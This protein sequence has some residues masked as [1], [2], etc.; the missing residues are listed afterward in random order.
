MEKRI[1]SFR[2]LIAGLLLML[3]GEGIACSYTLRLYDTYGDG[4]NGGYINILVNGIT[5]A[6][7]VTL[8]NG[9]GPFDYTLNVNQGDVVSTVYVAGS[10]SNENYYDVFDS[11]NS[12]VIRDG[13]N[14]Y[15]CTPTGGTLFT[16]VC[17]TRDVG[18]LSVIT[19]KTGCS[20]SSATTVTIAVMNNGIQQVDTVFL[21]YSIDGGL[22][23]S[24]VTVYQTL[25][26][27]DTL[28]YSFLQSAPMGLL[29]TYNCIFTA[30][31]NNDQYGLNDTLL[32]VI[33]HVATI[34]AF[35][36]YEDFESGSGG[37]YSGGNH[38]S[39][40]LGV[41]DSWTIDSAASDSMAWVTNLTGGY[42]DNEASW[43]ASPCFDFTGMNNIIFEMKLWY[44]TYQWYDGAALQYTLDGVNWMTIGDFNEPVNWY[45]N[46]WITGLV[47]GFGAYAGWSGYSNGYL[48]VSHVLPAQVNNQ[49]SVRFRVVFGSTSYHYGGY[50]GVAFDDVRIYQ[51]PPMTISNFFGFQSST[52]PLGKGMVDNSI[53]GFNIQTSSSTN[54]LAVTDL[55]FNTTGTTNSADIAMAR[56][57]YTA[58]QQTWSNF[59]QEVK[60]LSPFGFQDTLILQEG[61]NFFI[62]VYDI[63]SN[64]TAGNFVD[65]EI[66]SV[67][68]GGVWYVPTNNNPAGS[69]QIQ[70]PMNGTYIVNQQGGGDFLNLNEARQALQFRGV[71][72]PVEIVMMP[73]VYQEKVTFT[74]VFG[75]SATNT[76]TIRSF[77]NDSTTVT[78]QDSATDPNQN[79]VI[80][81]SNASFFTLKHLHIKTLSEDYSRAITFTGSTNS[82]RILNNFIEGSSIPQY[83]DTWLALIYSEA[84]NEGL[85]IKNNRIYRGSYGACLN[86]WNSASTD[87]IIVD[88][89]FEEQYAIG[90][91]LEWHFRPLIQGNLIT[92]TSGHNYYKG[93]QAYSLNDTFRISANT[94]RFI[95]NG[96]G[97]ALYWCEG[98]YQTPAVV[99]NNFIASEGLTAGYDQIGIYSS[100]SLRTLFVFNSINLYGQQNANSYPLFFNGS[101]SDCGIGNNALANRT[102]A[103]YVISISNTPGIQSDRN[104]F[105]LTG[106]M[107]GRYNGINAT[108]LPAWT[109]GTGYDNTST[110]SDPLFYSNTDLHTY[111]PILNNAGIPINSR[112]WDDIDGDPRHL[113]TPDIG[114]DEFNMPALEASFVEFLSPVG[115][116]GLGNEPVTIRIANN[117]TAA[118][119]GGLTA[120]YQILGGGIVSEA[121]PGTI[122][123]GDTLTF[124]FSALANLAVSSNDST[125]E[126]TGYISLVGDPVPFNDTGFTSVWSGYLPPAPV[127]NHVIVNYGNSAGLS[128]TGPGIKKWYLSQTDSIAVHT[129]DTL[130]IGPLYD[131][132]S[133]YVESYP[134]LAGSSG[135]NIALS[136]V[137]THSGGGAGTFGPAN[138]ND[139]NIPAYPNQP[140][141]W[142]STNGWIEYTWPAPV[143]FN[144]VKFYKSDRPMSSCSFQ[145]WDGSGYVTFFNYN[146]TV[147]DDSVGF[148][149]IT[150]SRIRFN[151][152]AGA[153]NPNFREIQVYAP[154]VTL[155]PSARVAVTAFVTAFPGTDAGITSVSQPAGNV[156]AGSTQP[157]EVVLKNYGLNPLT[158]VTIGWRLNNVLQTPYIWTGSLAHG[159]TTMVTIANQLIPPGPGCIKAW[160]QNPNNLPDN[161]NLN[162][163][164][165]AC[166]TGCMSGTYTIGP[167]ASGTFDF[168]SF[169]AAVNVLAAAGVCGPVIFEVHP[170]TYTEQVTIPLIPGTSPVNTVT[171]RSSTQDSSAVLLQFAATSTAN[172]WVVRFSG[173]QNI[174]FSHMTIRAT[175]ISNGRVIEFMNG[176]MNIV[177]DQ[178]FIST[179]T[180]S[181]STAFAGFY[182]TSNA[183]SNFI[184]INQ[185]KVDGGYYG[186]YHYGEWSVTKNGLMVTNSLFTNF[187]LYGIFTY[188]TNNIHIEG[189]T[190]I[191]RSNAGTL[192]PIYCSY[193]YMM[194]TI[195]RNRIQ[196]VNNGTYYG[197]WLSWCEGGVS[198][199]WNVSNNMI[200][201][202]GNTTSTAYGIYSQ[203]SWYFNFL[204]NTVRLQSGSTSNGRAFFHTSGSSV[205]VLNNIF[206]NYNGG[207]AYYVNSP[208]VI[209]ESN[210]NNFFTT[211]FNLAYWDYNFTNLPDLQSYSGKDLASHVIQPPYYS[212]QDLRIKN[213]AL[214][215]KAL[216]I[217]EVQV[218]FFGNQR[219]AT[220]TI[221]AHE[222]PLLPNDAG[223]VAITLPDGLTTYMEDD[224]VPVQ[225]VLQNFGLDTL[226][227][228][229]VSYRVNQMNPVNATYNGILPPNGIDTFMMP[230]FITPAGQSVICAYTSVNGDL[231]TF[232]DTTCIGHYALSNIDAELVM[233]HPFTEGCGLGMDTVTITIAN[234]ATA[235]IPSGFTASYRL[236]SGAVITETVNTIIPVGDTIDF[237]FATLVNL[238]TAADT[239]WNLKAWVT[240]QDDNIAMNDTASISILSLAAPPPPSVTSPVSTAFGTSAILDANSLLHTQWYTS[241][242]ST[243]PVGTGSVYQTPLLYDTTTYFAQNFYSSTGYDF[244]IGNATTQGTTNSYPNPYGHYYWGNKEQYLILASELAAANILAGEINALAFNVIAAGN[245]VLQNF[246]IKLGHTMQSNMNTN[247]ITGL[248]EVYSHPGYVH[249]VGWNSH[250]FHT[251]FMWDGISNLVVEVCFNNTSYTSHG[252]VSIAQPGFQSTIG[253]RSDAT[254]VC[255]YST[256]TVYSDR[257]VMKLACSSIGCGSLRVPVVVNVTGIPPLGKPLYTPESMQIA[258]NGCNATETRNIKVK[259]IGNASLTYQTYGG[260]HQVD[261]TSTLYYHASSYPDTTNHLF[262]NIPTSVDSLYLEITINGTYS[263]AAAFASLLIEGTNIG[264]IPDGNIAN[265][266]NITVTYA[267]GGTQ[268]ANWLIDGELQV[269]IGNSSSVT[270]WNGTRMHRVRAYTK[271]AG[272]AT[273]SQTTGVIAI[274]DSLD[275]PVLFSGSGLPEGNY[276]ANLPVKFSH[277]GYPYAK[278]PVNMTVTGAPDIHSAACLNFTPIFQYNTIIDSVKLYNLGCAPLQITYIQNSDTTFT[279]GFQQAT[280]APFDSIWLPVGF[281]PLLQQIYLDT[282][283]IKSNDADHYICLQGIGLSPP[284]IALSTDTLNLTIQNCDDTLSVPLTISNTGN[285]PLSW[286][287]ISGISLSDQFDNGINPLLWGSTTGVPSGSCG[288]FTAPNAL[289]FDAGGIR[290]AT[291]LPLNLLGGGSIDFYLKIANG[292]WPCEMADWGE[293][294]VLEYSTNQGN[295]WISVA[296]YITSNYPVFTQISQQIPQ[297][298]RTTATLLRWR[299]VSHS[300]SSYDNWAIDDVVVSNAMS[301]AAIIP[302][303]GTV[304][305]L[306]QQ[307]IQLLINT[308]QMTSGIYS[309]NLLFLSNDP[310]N[311]QKTLPFSL[312]L[313]GAPELVLQ[314][315]PCLIADTTQKGGV[316]MTGFTIQNDG[317]DTLYITSMTPGTNHFSLPVTSFTILPFQQTQVS[318]YFNP[319]DTGMISDTLTI[320]SNDGIHKLC[321]IGTALPAPEFLI[322]QDTLMVTI[323]QCNDSVIVPLVLV[324]S[325]Q[326]DLTWT[327]GSSTGL[328]MGQGSTGIRK[329]GVYN[330]PTIT[331]LLNTAPDIQATSIGNLDLATISQYDAIMNIRGS[332]VNQADVLSYIQTGGTWIGEWTSNDHP[333]IWGVIGGNI[334]QTGTS[335]TFG[336]NVL[337]PNHYLAQKINWSSLPYGANPTDFM[338]DLRN[339][340][341][342][343]AKV[344]V[345]ANHNAYP[346]NPLLV[347]KIWGAGKVIILNFDYND[348]PYYNTHVM[349]MIIETARYGASKAQWLSISP[350]QG[351]I[352][353]AASQNLSVKFNALG[354]NSGT[355]S[356]WI[357][358]NSN[359]PKNLTD[360]VYCVMTV[361]GAPDFRISQ[362]AGCLDFDTLI[363]GFTSTKSVWI[364]NDG[365]DTLFINSVS[366]TWAAYTLSA[367]SF[368]ILPHD[369]ASLQIT[370]IPNAAQLFADNLIFNTN[371][372]IHQICLNGVGIDAPIIS[373]SPSSLS[374]TF[375][376]CNDSVVKT[377]TIYNTG[378]GDLRYSMTNLFGAT[379]N[380]TSTQ[381]YTTSGATTNH[382]FQNVPL[383][384]DSM[385][386]IVTINGD[387]D[388]GSEYCSLMIEGANLGIV[389]DNNLANGTNIIAE[390]IFSG[391]QLQNWLVDGVLN[392]SIVNHPNVDHWSGLVSMHRVQVIINGVP[393]ISVNHV[394]DTVVSGDSSVVLVSFKT[395]GLPNG[396]YQTNIQI[397]SNDP[398]NQTIIVPCTLTVN[399]QAALTASKTCVHFGTT[400]QYA[401]K[402][403]T[404][405]ITNTGCNTL[406]ISSI[407]TTLSHFSLNASY[408]TIAPGQSTQLIVT[409]LPT[410]VGQFTDNIYLV[411]N[412]GTHQVC[413][414]GTGADASILNVL[415]GSFTKTITAC[416]DTISDVVQIQNLGTGN[417]TYQVYG[418]RGLSGDSTILV[419]RDAHPWNVNIEQ[420]IQTNFGIVPDVIT[421]SQIASTNFGLYDVIITA[422]NQS[423]SYYNTLSAQSAKF[424]TFAGNGGIVLYM[425]A[426]YS[427]NTMTMAGGVNMVYGNAENQN[428]IVQSSHLIVQG[429]SNPLNGGNA[430]ANYMTN[431]P[432][433]SRII[434][435]T[436][437]SGSPTTAE[438]EL[439]SG[440]VIATGMLWEYHST[441]PGF[442]MQPMLHRAI[443]Y[444]LG[445]IGT[446]PSW[447]SFAY[448]ADTLF[449]IGNTNVTVKFNSTGI[450]NGVYQSNIIVYSNDPVTPQK[451]I[452]CTLTVN[453][454]A[455]IAL[456]AQCLHYDTV[457][458]GATTTRHLT[459]RNTG[460]ANLVVHSISAGI[461]QYQVVSGGAGTIA[462]GDS[463]I[464]TVSFLP[465][466]I[467]TYSSMLT[468]STNLGNSQVCL[469]GLSIN[470]PVVAV[471]PTAFD[472]TIN[473]C[474]DTVT[475]TLK[476]VNTGL[477]NA[478]Y[479]I[480]G[481]YGSDIDQTSTIPF[482]T[483]GALTTHTFNNIPPNTD[484]LLLEVTL[485]GDFDQPSEFATLIIEGATIGV[486]NDGDVT[487]GTPVTDYY[488]FGGAQ[489]SNWL[490]DGQLSVLVQN[491]ATVDH[492]S[493]LTSFHRVRLLV[494]GN[495]WIQVW[496]LMDTIP[497]NDSTTLAVKFFSTN[498][499]AGTH[500]YTML[501]GSND[502]GNA[503]VPVHCTLNVI[504][505]AQM[506]VSQN[507]LNFNSIMIGANQVKDL[508][509]HNPGCDTLKITQIFSSVP[510]I[511]LPIASAVVMPK[512]TLT[513]PVTFTPVVSGSFSGDIT[514]NSNAGN[515][516][517]CL[518]AT[519]LPAPSIQVTATTLTSNL[520]CSMTESK[521]VV[522]RNQGQAPLT[523][524]FTPSGNNF[525]SISNHSGTVAAGDSV[526]VM[527]NFNKQGLPLGTYMANFQLSS[528]DPL[529]P[530]TTIS[531]TLEI[532]N[533][534]IPVNLGPDIQVCSNQQVVLNAG[535]MYTSYLWDDTSADSLR[536][537]FTSGTYHVTVMDPNG[538]PSS[539]TVQVTFYPIP[540][541][542]AGSDTAICTGSSFERSG[543]ATGSIL[544]I[545]TSQIGSSMTFGGS[546]QA[547][548]FATNYTASR[549]QI[550]WR[551]QEMINAG[552]KRGMIETIAFNVGSVGNPDT[553]KEFYIRIKTTT[554]NSLAGGFQN[555][556]FTV[557]YHPNQTLQAGWFTFT[558]NTPFFYDGMDNVVLEICFTNSTYNFGSSVQYHS[559]SFGAASIFGTSY[560]TNVDGCALTSY[561]STS[562]RPNI[563]IAGQ[564]DEGN[565]LWTGPGGFTTHAPVLRIPTATSQFAGFYHLYVDNGIGCNATHAFNLTLSPL[566]V[567][568]AGADTSIFEGGSYQLQPVVSGGIPPYTYVWS[569]AATLSDPSVLQPLATPTTTTTYTLS[570][571]GSNGCSA[572]DAMKLSVI[573]RYNISGTFSYNN[574]AF[575]PMT[576]SMVY[577][578]NASHV[579][580]DSVMADAG[581][582]YTFYLRPPGTYYLSGRT[583][584][585][586]GGVNST[587]ALVVQRHVIN[588]NP[589]SGLRLVGADVNLSQTV[590]STDAL[591]ILR[592]TLGMD[593]TFAADDWVYDYPAVVITN[594]HVQKSIQALASGDV[595]GSYLPPVMRQY[596]LV[597]VK[598]AG[599][600][601]RGGD[602]IEIP[603]RSGQWAHLGAV[604]LVMDLPQQDVIIE[605]VTSPLKGLMYHVYQGKLRIAWSDEQGHLVTPGDLLLTLRLKTNGTELPSFWM[606]PTLESEIT[607]VLAQVLDPMLLTAPSL[608][609]GNQELLVWNQPNPF[610]DKTAIY[611]NVPEEGVLEIEVFDL[612]GRSHTLLRSEGL[613][614][615]EH[616]FEVDALQWPSGIY[617]Y[618]ITLTTGKST[619][620]TNQSMILTR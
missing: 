529:V 78:I 527:F 343:Q 607:D 297:G 345:S 544:I 302:D 551:K 511:T 228:I 186:I 383:I 206:S 39:W 424:T 618:R 382:Q 593:T 541:V 493:G 500:Y 460:C 169:G 615:G 204:N 24:N 178:C 354:V 143:T 152:L 594:N 239:T 120:Y 575:T 619:Y 162:D 31:T 260:P 94:I 45:N 149:Q 601:T 508:T 135:Q 438:Y 244:I 504:G 455:Q 187:Y 490:S 214:S 193:G 507:C 196:S 477:G 28:I 608:T 301:F 134:T 417:L 84:G 452:P 157:V 248:T 72:G 194:G 227:S 497:S 269:R 284:A 175:G 350:N 505:S 8:N 366:N 532:P 189:N 588:L 26:P 459:I 560:N 237:T 281:S 374:H 163:T 603:I 263:S 207:Y 394:A 229:P 174:K 102:G 171:F 559:S 604:T 473:S 365:C 328:T 254:G 487:A 478:I 203:G 106:G 107:L 146:S 56:I 582:A 470:P 566:P 262:N 209:T 342:P 166:F 153:N 445:A 565:Y 543:V 535:A 49:S 572:S 613:I 377:L 76:I 426:N 112:V 183:P 42:N 510:S 172:N 225:V 610:R 476:L 292:S 447:L 38:S 291:T 104:N 341:D 180:T 546:V 547:T 448:T 235:I 249:F 323:Q 218:D 109:A 215:G 573:P 201:H 600:V 111:S 404:L 581:G 226:Y 368:T 296:T 405:V 217:P 52:D 36:Y 381:Y 406:V 606:H 442:N 22:T 190:L 333:F 213:T 376:T 313:V 20:L 154:V 7:G 131:T 358:F 137:A 92:S 105:Y 440:L 496:P 471:V 605:S 86:S 620:R 168:N 534:L 256:G 542:D 349:N 16:A 524:Q 340:N 238:G 386:V 266:Q 37:W 261:T 280:I 2:T 11:Y 293:D 223:V 568:N 334:P 540:V 318:L 129:G 451:L 298:A 614:P 388:D 243:N 210:H 416:N 418:G 79:W 428:M 164:S 82:I 287:G 245:L 433:G 151:A 27:G 267:F 311:P 283:V 403:D 88:N 308:S 553:L 274:G 538:C 114:A 571:T 90:I 1:L 306:G 158:T 325:G 216:A 128:A 436:N 378:I 411:T 483:N 384:S 272:W 457:L 363:Q 141:G 208:W 584:K 202:Q 219:T 77:A 361:V 335:G 322:T 498:M 122:Q 41:P 96:I 115:D 353:P 578:H 413:L 247:F 63:D 118:I 612:L 370:F 599:F 357:H 371:D 271:A 161:F 387:F 415:P 482:V 466:T 305:P 54:P 51:P 488:G 616:R 611:C 402:K 373:Y 236:Q 337:I 454:S 554:A 375:I 420:Y 429:L 81:F 140:W 312:T 458:Q 456:G 108:N 528:N 121:V 58:N 563:R 437:L 517:V 329:I 364:Y 449:G 400:M 9:F 93:I 465:Q 15:S 148:P 331:N 10:W 138:Y 232:N 25:L 520:A 167:S 300:G 139:G 17:P 356:T 268:L 14:D 579:V 294:V 19:P 536:Q 34:S 275:I 89:H 530:Q 270:P 574:A 98:N 586:W 99:A 521:P 379:Y 590:S 67:L 132:T 525:L 159:A 617:H 123:P 44:E 523:Y 391:Q 23:Y 324:N 57:W 421:S 558:L 589:L 3:A 316:S 127:P 409:F 119:S 113:L 425:L 332:N 501:I 397:Q 491:A 303:T 170:A 577:L 591:L 110:V 557:Y 468:I 46:T 580:L 310:L 367:Q 198:S 503:Q 87:N 569:P 299:Q 550:L 273:M 53:I 369:S 430:N 314:P 173:A 145:Y 598:T 432:A 47:S 5:V 64:A 240:I 18:V 564:V 156:L 609:S 509:I 583:I 117:G 50:D 61:N 277:P 80:R 362:Q 514:I 71:N 179:N 443:S 562:W 199:R 549:R 181:T 95:S 485:S 587:D 548:P 309:G 100:Y 516:L 60:P 150:S 195:T 278:I 408:L 155:C 359:D 512:T 259:N 289:Y 398:V 43:V 68:I 475:Q 545:K 461:P 330:S 597:E 326:A 85:Q 390:Y 241:P 399:G 414:S 389:P 556:M 317:C 234:V 74:P 188:Y 147:I 253:T 286:T 212:A 6:T 585:P 315:F 344:I 372:G 252:Y 69:R 192:Y 519:G 462:A 40:A 552:F 531:C 13:C 499:N 33:T 231:N 506:T 230:M 515:A 4:W 494:N 495:H 319:L 182:S 144:A 439:G 83:E 336:A 526:T 467:G 282:L 265:G 435:R 255:N 533:M 431:L 224:V 176:A 352:A 380:Q 101:H 348:D 124:T 103:G 233:I 393:W 492:W 555:N 385:K 576:N 12:F 396:T 351:V 596:P 126:F 257:P 185:C 320:T 518:T 423:V 59:G 160:T 66:D 422:G 450:P 142:V 537:V 441:T 479:H 197:I 65:A 130:I 392:I 116:C 75:A 355:Y 21:S 346:N 360:S 339:L 125:F 480:L 592:R 446:S 419:I 570:V 205:R 513:I 288:S 279:P 29:G 602:V 55:R 251:P 246:S 290:H 444:A 250:N 464:V 453:G 285:A 502:P 62:L 307:T 70:P 165:Q 264:I 242:T 73:G 35:P 407:Y 481:I 91:K 412:V 401:Q 321:L 200:S 472:V 522:I 295:T 463:M 276:Y 347:E 469:E 539:D 97:I 595:N 191:N 184:T 474:A 395:A 30:T 427:V 177:I 567:V 211:G 221:G 220:P 32:D 327:L 222:V 133:A 304:A 486:I 136:A 338:R 489:L 410:A 48:T 434:T 484:T 258:L 561:Q